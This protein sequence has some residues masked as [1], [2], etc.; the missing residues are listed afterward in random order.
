MECP[1]LPASPEPT[2]TRLLPTLCQWDSSWQALHWLPPAK[3]NGQFSV[4][5]WTLQ[6]HLIHSVDLLLETLSFLVVSPPS[7]VGSVPGLHP[8]ITSCLL[9][10]PLILCDLIPSHGFTLHLCDG[11]SSV[12]L[13][14]ELETLMSRWRCKFFTWLQDLVCPKSGYFPQNL[15]FL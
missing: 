4:L 7:Q 3:S 10:I 14:P 15:I 13:S 6:Q 5:I 8:Y 2:P 9:Y 1:L 11:E 12:V